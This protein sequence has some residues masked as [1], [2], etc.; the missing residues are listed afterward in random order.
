MIFRS[1]FRAPLTAAL[2]LA[3][4]AGAA[5][6][7]YPDKPM[8]MIV[9][10]A[11]GGATDVVARPLGV[12]LRQLWKQQVIVENKPGAGGNIGADMVAK[13]AGDG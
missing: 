3:T 10:F 5:T 2:S 6:A 7:V 13:S 12:R 11:P 4:A 9:P 8:R 1:K